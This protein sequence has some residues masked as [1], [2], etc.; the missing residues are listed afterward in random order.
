MKYANLAEK[1]LKGVILTRKECLSVL[2]T[3]PSEI[4]ELVQAAFRV[5]E[6]H[7]GR[8]VRLHILV[9][10]KSGLCSEN[11]S[12]CSQSAASKAPIDKYPMLDEDKIVSGAWAA[13][14][15]KAMRY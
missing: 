7:F 15:A 11:C 4:L 3:S 13:K 14:E 12:Y 2:Q 1:S 10:A 5:R 8:K 6:A 9:N